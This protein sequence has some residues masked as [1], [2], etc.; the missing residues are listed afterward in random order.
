MNLLNFLLLFRP[1]THNEIT[2]LYH[3]TER[4]KKNIY[5]E[6]RHEFRFYSTNEREKERKNGRKKLQH[7]NGRIRFFK[8]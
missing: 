8:A 1:A 7:S 4:T 5:T 3:G 2:T 6:K